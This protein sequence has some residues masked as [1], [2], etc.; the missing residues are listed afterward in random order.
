VHLP[1]QPP[2]QPGKQEEDLD[3]FFPFDPYLLERSAKFLDLDGS[4]VSWAS[5]HEQAHA[6]DDDE[7]DEVGQAVGEVTWQPG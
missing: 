3:M 5:R 6:A 1:L 4:Y 2:P 7:D